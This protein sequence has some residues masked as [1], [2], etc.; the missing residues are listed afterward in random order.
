MKKNQNG[1]LYYDAEDHVIITALLMLKTRWSQT[2][3]TQALD[4]VKSIVSKIKSKAIRLGLMDKKRMPLQKVLNIWN[5][6]TPNMTYLAMLK[7]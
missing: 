1:R 6:L 3:L 7:R 2:L 4:I 5:G